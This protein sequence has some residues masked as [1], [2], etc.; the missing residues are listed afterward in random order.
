MATWATKD[1]PV[2]LHSGQVAKLLNCSQDDVCILANSG[3][4]RALGKP[5]PNAVKYF[6]T[7]E[8]ITLAGDRPWLDEVTKTI[9]QYWR[10]KNERRRN[11]GAAADATSE[12]ADPE[13][14]LQKPSLNASA[15]SSGTG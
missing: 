1:L 12:A 14:R 7:L 4:L 5:K 2:R 10:R 3:K 6:S 15:I 9:S 8:L 13:I 11:F